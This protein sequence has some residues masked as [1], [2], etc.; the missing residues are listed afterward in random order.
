[1]YFEDKRNFAFFD[2]DV[3]AATGGSRLDCRRL[4]V[5]FRDA[6]ETP[7]SGAEPPKPQAPGE[8]GGLLGRKA[9]ERLFADENV[10]AAERRMDPDASLRYQMEI[11]GANLTYLAES[12]KAYMRGPGRMRILSRERPE[13]GK[14][15]PLGPRP[16]DEGR[17]WADPLPNGYSR[18][19]IAWAEGMAYDGPTDRAYFKG[20]V[21]S[22]HIGRGVPG[23]TG[24][25][26]PESTTTKIRSADLQVAFSESPPTASAPAVP[27]EERMGVEKM[28]ADGGVQLWVDD[29]RGSARRL[30]YQRQPELLRLYSGPDQWARLWQSNEALQEF[31][32]VAA[33]VVTFYPATK[34]VDMVDQQELVVTPR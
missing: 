34:R 29:R 5:Y 30:M 22:I 21:E 33:R 26:R 11:A 15:P 20:N 18:T 4:W 25:P 17:F 27:R 2:T 6:P 14:T 8:L 3:K 28:V 9:I 23:E 24:A 31:G 19:H 13:K 12:R 32:E 16:E 7:A 1:M 10:L